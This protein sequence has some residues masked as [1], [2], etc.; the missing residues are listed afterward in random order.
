MFSI[1]RESELLT[2][3]S[4]PEYFPSPPAQH[5]LKILIKGDGESKKQWW[6]RGG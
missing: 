2:D 5:A 4:S 1:L 3:I 6:W